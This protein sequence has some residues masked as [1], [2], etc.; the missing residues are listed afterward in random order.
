MLG[1]FGKIK[2]DRL[3]ES[4]GR[5]FSVYEGTVPAGPPAR[6]L[7]QR[8]AEVIAITRYGKLLFAWCWSAPKLS[9]LLQVPNSQAQFGSGPPIAI[10]PAMLTWQT[11]SRP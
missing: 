3:V 11:T 9:E 5:L 8:D 4:G 7:E 1:H 10:G 2:S 6:N